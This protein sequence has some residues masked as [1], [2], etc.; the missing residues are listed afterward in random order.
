MA[1]AVLEILRVVLVQMSRPQ[2]HRGLWVGV[3]MKSPEMAASTRT[4]RDTRGKSPSPVSR[5]TGTA[6]VVARREVSHPEDF[7]KETSSSS[8]YSLAV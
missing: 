1:V 7:G 4:P 2:T 3:K 6:A 5:W 8:G